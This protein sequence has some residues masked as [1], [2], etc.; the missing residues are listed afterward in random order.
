MSARR[1]RARAAI[2]A[3]LRWL[4]RNDPLPKAP[5]HARYTEM[6]RRPT[7]GERANA[8][9]WF[10]QEDDEGLSWPQLATDK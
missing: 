10:G 9:E 4:D 3:R 6:N 8:V 7:I 5:R 1:A 2:T